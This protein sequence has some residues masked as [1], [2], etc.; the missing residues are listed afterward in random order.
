MQIYHQPPAPDLDYKVRAPLRL[1]LPEGG[2]VAISNWSLAGIYYPE[3]MDIFPQRGNLIIPFQGVD[4]RFAVNFT[5]G[6]AK[7]ELLFDNLKGRERETL[8]IF[9]RAILSGQMASTE[10]IITAL[11]TPVDLIPMGETEEEKATA[12]KKER[13]L[14][15]FLI[16]AFFYSFVG[17]LIFILFFNQLWISLSSVII[18]NGK[19]VAPTAVIRA[20]Y[21]G[22][23]KNILVEEG[24]DVSKGDILAN[25]KV[26]QLDETLDALYVRR[27]TQ[28]RLINDA[29]MAL[30]RHLANAPT[31]HAQ[32]EAVISKL[33]NKLKEYDKAPKQETAPAPVKQNPKEFS[34]NSISKPSSF[35]EDALHITIKTEP[36]PK[37][38]EKDNA[39]YKQELATA[40]ARLQDFIQGKSKTPGDF[41]DIRQI[42]EE[43]S[44]IENDVGAQID[45]KI[46]ALKTQRAVGVIIAPTAGI[47][48]K[49]HVYA[50]APIFA[51]DQIITIENRQ[52]RKI[53]GELVKRRATKVF[54]GMAAQVGILTS[55]GKRFIAA[56]IENVEVTRVSVANGKLGAAVHI[57]IDE[58]ASIENAE[59]ITPGMPVEIR[60]VKPWAAWLNFTKK[61]K[62]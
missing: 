28:R 44:K 9:Y 47:I 60:A 1:E 46:N 36:S 59:F 33:E 51:S 58:Q 53:S 21:E 29:E 32:L 54:P 24:Q 18:Y 34:N 30:K 41:H 40:R 35:S 45:E 19:V 2:E 55:E 52:I 23:I 27:D 11:D 25:L 16:R 42:L 56:Q 3:E 22:V 26:A 4:I 14:L 50:G 8:A 6:S 39:R 48:K 57:M 15:R 37:I 61:A 12:Q 49:I 20:G 13:K 7:R 10:N 43:K 62:E 31:N 17:G 5:K 38:S